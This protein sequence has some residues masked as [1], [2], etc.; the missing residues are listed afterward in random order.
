MAT[1]KISRDEYNTAFRGKEERAL[2]QALENR[3][4]EIQLYWNRATYFWA[5]IGATFVGYLAVQT[6]DEPKVR[7]D[8]SVL[9]SCFGIVFSFAWLLVNRGSKYW[10]ENWENHVD[11]LEGEFIGPL[12]KT[13]L[14][15]SKTSGSN[16]K[17]NH[18]VTGPSRISVSK[19]NQIVSLFVFLLWVII[20]FHSLFQFSIPAIF[21]HV[22]TITIICC[23]TLIVSGETYK[24][25]HSYEAHK[26][27]SKIQD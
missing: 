16:E 9:L 25:Y 19:V 18:L 1:T 2:E 4:F 27:C 14:S 23:I 17:L 20:L 13:N 15:R 22:A 24:E 8:M 21:F 11:I 12:F 3:K 5:F 10:Q 7:K 26:R 6:F